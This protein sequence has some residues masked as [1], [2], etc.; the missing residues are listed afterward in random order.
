MSTYAQVQKNISG[1]YKMLM[2]QSSAKY[3]K[4]TL[5]GLGIL[6]SLFLGY[7]LHSYYVQKREQKA[8]G[9]L[10]EVIDSFEKSQYEMLSHD[11]NQDQE[12]VVSAWQDTEVLVD[13]LYKENSG[14]YL[15]PYFLMFKSQ[16]LLE[17]GGDVDKAR[18][19]LEEALQQVPKSSEM[20]SLFNLKRIKMSLDSL[21]EKTREQALHDLVG[22][23]KNEEGCAFEEASYLLGS[24]YI[25]MGEKDKAVKVWENVVKFAD[26]KKTLLE[27]PWV[28]QSQ[29]KLHSIKHA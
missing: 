16:I 12:K 8:F 7:F 24:Y 27:S 22:L 14:S 28:K 4:E 3:V 6:A 19:I 15:A 9:A 5:L 20:Y 2:K 11:K 23:T 10:V 26:D 29:E 13:A 25:S 17:R 1:Y 21:D 18:A